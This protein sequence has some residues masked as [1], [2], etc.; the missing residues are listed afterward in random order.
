MLVQ[1][2]DALGYPRFGA[3]GY[4]IGASILSVMCLDYPDR[5]IGYH[6][7]EPANAMPYTGIGSPPL[8]DAEQA[9]LDLQ[10]RWYAAEGGY[11]LI[12]ATRPQTLAY[13]LTDSPAGLAAWILDKWYTWTEPPGGDLST[14]FTADQLLANVTIYWVTGTINAA[15]RRYY[16]RDHNPRPR[17]TADKITVPAGIAL[18]TQAIERAPREY[19][20]RVFTDIRYWRDLGAGGHFVMLERPDLL[21]D[22]IRDFFRQL[23]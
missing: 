6:T 13:G 11:D 18:T 3:H 20:E 10:D 5:V 15:N 17:T 21:A 22:S 23:R 12:Q 9:Y 2:M 4:D 7:T 19:L 14:R 16:E 1:L 8:T